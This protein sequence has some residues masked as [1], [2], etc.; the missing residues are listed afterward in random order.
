MKHQGN[1]YDALQDTNT[2]FMIEETQ[3]MPLIDWSI[4]ELFEL[5]NG[6]LFYGT[7][8]AFLKCGKNFIAIRDHFYPNRSIQNIVNTYYT[9]KKS[10]LY[11]DYRSLIHVSIKRYY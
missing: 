10:P 11:K 1:I 7:K 6:M 5:K 2:L 8:K 4:E 9:W 3:S